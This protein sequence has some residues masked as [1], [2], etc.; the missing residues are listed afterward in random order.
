VFLNY[1]HADE[2]FGVAMLD[3]ELS[4]RFG[5]ESVFFASKSI[6]LGAAWEPEMLTAVERSTALLVV[7]GRNWLGERDSTGRRRVDDPDDFVRREILLAMAHDKAVIPVR[8]GIPRLAA[9]DLPEELRPLLTRQD[10]EIR[11]RTT[12]PDVDRLETKLRRLIPGLAKTATTTATPPPGR[13]ATYRDNA[14]HYEFRDLTVDTFHA[15]PSFHG[16][17]NPLGAQGDQR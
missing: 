6:E 8:L 14:S 12:G 11:F 2:P 3:R 10:I 17:T 5:S 7:M 4:T 1:R 16:A 9:A 15:G 13:T